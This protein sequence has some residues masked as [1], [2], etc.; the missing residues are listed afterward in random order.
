MWTLALAGV[1][2]GAALGTRFNAWT[3]LFAN[4]V[5]VLGM[6]GLM[7]LLGQNVSTIFWT[8]GL[9]VLGLQFGYFGGAVVA[10]LIGTVTGSQRLTPVT[11]HS[12]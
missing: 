5:C 12:R 10:Q 8:T 9:T 1:L 11:R 3:L 6:P 2:V 4:G 7:M